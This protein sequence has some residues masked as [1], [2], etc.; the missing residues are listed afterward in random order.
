[1]SKLPR[2]TPET[3]PEPGSA[4]A[5]TKPANSSE[6]NNTTSSRRSKWVAPATNAIPAPATFPEAYQ[7]HLLIGVLTTTALPYITTNTPL[8]YLVT[9]YAATVASQILHDP[10]HP[11][12]EQVC[13]FHT[14]APKWDVQR[15]A[16]WWVHQILY[17]PAP[18]SGGLLGGK[19]VR[20]TAQDGGS[21]D[22]SDVKN[23]K[24]EHHAGLLFLV[25]YIFASM[26][27]PMDLDI[28]RQRGTFEPLLAI[29]ADPYCPQD[30]YEGLLKILWR[31]TGIEGG[32]TTLI[33]RTG[34][35]AWVGARID[36]AK[37]EESGLAS[38]QGLKALVGRL[39]QTCDKQRVG[40][41]SKG[42]IG[43]VLG[44]FDLQV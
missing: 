9:T 2:P 1:M 18:I 14:R 11:M 6:S 29:A 36:L 43:D 26:R 17:T 3:K 10:L 33:T 24:S 28:L 35:L 39:W 21:G 22:G 20:G 34:V 44:Q 38:V 31:V 41:W 32:S 15:L 4:E 5:N 25:N 16:S 7:Y 40:E 42:T 37:K 23:A 13:R 8:P 12:Y 19:H 30:V 27:T